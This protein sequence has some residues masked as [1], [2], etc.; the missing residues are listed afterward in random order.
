[1][2]SNTNTIAVGVGGGI[3]EVG[4]VSL[5]ISAPLAI[6]PIAGRLGVRGGHS[7]PVWVGVVEGGVG[8]VEVA[9]VGLG[10]AGGNRDDG[11]SNQKLEHVEDD[12]TTHCGVRAV[13]MIS[14]GRPGFIYAGRSNLSHLRHTESVEGEGEGEPRRRNSSNSPGP[15]NSIEVRSQSLHDGANSDSK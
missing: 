3:A 2:S 8:S 12:D 13:V 4:G 5:S 9:R 11:S 14:A 6:A 7:W 10:L 15:C 1:M